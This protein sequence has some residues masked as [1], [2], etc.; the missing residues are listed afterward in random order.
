M[1]LKSLD[2]TPYVVR[3]ERRQNGEPLAL[4]TLYSS[5]RFPVRP[6]RS[7][8]LALEVSAEELRFGTF[9]SRDTRLAVALEA[10]TLE[11]DATLDSGRIRTNARLDARSD[12]PEFTLQLAGDGIALAADRSGAP[13]SGTPVVD[14]NA[15]LSGNGQSSQELVRSLD[16]DLLVYLRGGK[17]PAT[18]LRFLFGSIVFQL[19]GVINP[20]D[21]RQTDVELEC[22]GA[23]FQVADGVV[24]TENGIVMQTPALQVVGLGN[25]DLA[26]GELTM[27]FR[28]K[29]REG[30]V[31][32]GGIVNEFVQITGTLDAPRID[33][34]PESAARRG[35]FAIATGGLSLLAGDL[36]KRITAG[37]VCPD[38]PAVV[39]APGAGN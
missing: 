20:F 36:F 9:V 27:R 22:A 13:A 19:L 10:A 6:L 3:G 17:I 16:G 11:V 8:Q 24:S 38:L 29:H 30:I 5:E 35:L 1:Q 4:H 7:A 31:N 2:L 21:E 34:S 15:T 37:D 25:V 18:G 28:T 12:H 26:T 32:I 23:Y 14:V 33:L 39:G